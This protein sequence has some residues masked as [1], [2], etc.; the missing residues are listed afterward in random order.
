MGLVCFCVKWLF[1]FFFLAILVVMPCVLLPIFLATKHLFSAIGHTER[2]PL[3]W[4][5]PEILTLLQSL[6]YAA[7]VK[8]TTGEN[9]R[10]PCRP[11]TPYT[12]WPRND[13][14]S[15]NQSE[16]RTGRL[17]PIQLLSWV[18]LLL[19]AVGDWL[20]ATFCHADWK[21]MAEDLLIW[22]K[23]LLRETLP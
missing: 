15:S 18:D 16:M 11:S 19:I 4:L 21:E 12:W 20:E 13:W 3:P 6:V 23:R 1:F 7:A 10:W 14:S 17:Q 8:G 22:Q 9:S 5:P 2:T